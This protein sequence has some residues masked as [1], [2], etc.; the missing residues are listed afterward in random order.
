M[1]IQGFLGEHRFIEEATLNDL[2]VSKPVMTNL[3]FDLISTNRS[4]VHYKIQVKS[5]SLIHENGCCKIKTSTRGYN[6]RST[7][8]DFFAIYIIPLDVWYIIPHEHVPCKL[9]TF[10]PSEEKCKYHKWK[11]R[12]DLLK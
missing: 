10:Y 5:C 12:W 7:D 9:S 2:D 4:N 3:M 1:N 6:Y 11:N 8:V